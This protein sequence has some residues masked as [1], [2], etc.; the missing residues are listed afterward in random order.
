[1]RFSIFFAGL[2]GLASA[3]GAQEAFHAALADLESPDYA[4]REDAHRRILE[5]WANWSDRELAALEA[6]AA[7]TDV[8]L[9][10]AAR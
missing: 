8:D 4:T 9:A 3:S 5:G 7:V 10:H 1:M 2:L 6:L